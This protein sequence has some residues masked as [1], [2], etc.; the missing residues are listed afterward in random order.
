MSKRQLDILRDCFKLQWHE[1]LRLRRLVLKDCRHEDIHDLRVAARRFRAV[2]ALLKPFCT[3]RR[4]QKLTKAV[5][6][7]VAASGDLRN[8]DEARCF[9]ESHGAMELF[10]MFMDRLAARSLKER[11]ALIVVVSDFKPK[12][13]ADHVSV[14]KADLK[15]TAGRSARMT[16]MDF[17]DGC[18]AAHS[19]RVLALLPAA[20]PLDN[21]AERHTLRI[22]IKKCRYFNEIYSRIAARDQSVFL[23]QLK[24]YQGL[25]GN[26]NDLKVFREIVAKLADRQDLSGLGLILDGENAHLLDEFSQLVDRDPL[27]NSVVTV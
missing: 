23:E 12:K 25:L 2:L 13:M 14:I 17:M 19:A 26:L 10:P 16:M 24:V 11:H 22:A 5:R 18:A 4:V 8:L 15:K 9:F 20:L 7:L 6:R 1:L 21:S 3:A 27:G